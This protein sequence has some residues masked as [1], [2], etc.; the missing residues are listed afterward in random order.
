M[1]SSYSG[2]KLHPIQKPVAALARLIRSFTLPGELVLDGFCGS[3][4][5][6]RSSAPGRPQVYRH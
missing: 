2:N 6:M 3:G 5:D 4:I 1:E